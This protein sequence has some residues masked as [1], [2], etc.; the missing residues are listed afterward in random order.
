MKSLGLTR[1][2]LAIGMATALLAGCGGSQPSVGAPEAMPEGRAIAG[3]ASST[4]YN[5]IYSFSG[6][7]D[8]Q[9]PVAS[10]I[11]VN[12]TLYGTTYSGGDCKY[13]L[14]CGTVFSITPSGT[15][16]VLHTFGADTDGRNPAAG[17]IDVGGTFYGTTSG[18]GANT[19]APRC[20]GSDYF[21][22]GTVF[23]ITPSGMENVV[24][25]FGNGTDGL[26][27]V[28]SLI[29]VNGTLYGT[30]QHG[31]AHN[32][33]NGGCGTVFSVTPSDAENVLR[34]FGKVA[35]GLGPAA[36]LIEVKGKLYGTTGGGGAYGAG[37]VFS[38]TLSGKVKVLHSFG[39]GTDGADPSAGLIDVD[40]MLYG[41]TELGGAIIS[42]HFCNHAD[43][44]GTVFSI[45]PSGTEKVLHRFTGGADGA[46]PV[47]SLISVKGTLYGTTQFGGTYSCDTGVKCGTI[48]S[49][50]PSGTE[51]VLHSFGSST[52]GD[53]P[54]AALTDVNAT[55]Y[56]TTTGGGA[57]QRGTVFAF[58]P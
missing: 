5:V 34:R 51:K 24:H 26:D 46:A 38:I 11:D 21:P 39:S 7:P 17:L 27:P 52:D 15:E 56:G 20:T 1:Y 28:A 47:A 23:S 50:T 42:S 35:D 53:H 25:S 48:F 31:G 9:S 57:H 18:G 8:A 30:T 58:K 40:G 6:S 37:T 14:Y 29:E 33:C 54:A 3:R 13:G 49:I 44:C 22:C 41:T 32:K 4:S 12:G 55:L 10:L 19:S 45:T 16:K 43:S 2:A 36:P